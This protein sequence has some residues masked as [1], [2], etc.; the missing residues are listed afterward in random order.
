MFLVLRCLWWDHKT[1]V[2]STYCTAMITYC[3]WYL[4]QKWSMACL[5]IPHKNRCYRSTI[6]LQVPLSYVL[7]KPQSLLLESLPLN[8][9]ISAWNGSYQQG[10]ESSLLWDVS[11]KRSEARA[12]AVMHRRVIWE[13]QKALLSQSF[14]IW[15][16]GRKL[17]ATA[18]G[19][20]RCKAA[21]SWSDLG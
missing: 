20:A 12:S 15:F 8:P 16:L 4:G 10:E 13:M 5:R 9:E 7:S 18:T 17:A 21:G 14:G 3:S 11:G 6:K 1:A 19:T 2:W